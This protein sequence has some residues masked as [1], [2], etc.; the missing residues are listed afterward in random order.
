MLFTQCVSSHFGLPSFFYAPK[1]ICDL[2]EKDLFLSFS[3][4]MVFNENIIVDYDLFAF[5]LVL[6]RKT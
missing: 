6:I 5:A 3:D 2:Q 4:I 1:Q